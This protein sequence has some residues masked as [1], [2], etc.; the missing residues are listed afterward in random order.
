VALSPPEILEPSKNLQIANRNPECRDVRAIST[1]KKKFD[2]SR[3]E[4]GCETVI[5]NKTSFCIARFWV[6]TFQAKA[7]L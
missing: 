3:N 5:E 4:L 6:Y 2:R 1:E 7:L